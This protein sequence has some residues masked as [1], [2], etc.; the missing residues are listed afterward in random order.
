MPHETALFGIFF[1][2]WAA[3]FAGASILVPLTARLL[4]LCG[5]DVPGRQ[6]AMLF[7]FALY[8]CAI[9]RWGM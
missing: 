1:S 4:G 3:A 6:W 2:P 9:F 7:F 8:A 5:L